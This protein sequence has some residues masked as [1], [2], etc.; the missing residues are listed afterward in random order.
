MSKAQTIIITFIVLLTIPF[1]GCVNS[2]KQTAKD[3]APVYSADWQSLAKHNESP[4]WFRDAK[5]GIYF[6]WGVYS[7]PA[8]GSEWYPRWMHFS[9]RPEYKYH[10]E[11]YGHSSEFGYHDFVPMFK[12]EKFDADEW[13]ELFEKTGAKFAG[14][15]AEHHDGFSMWASKVTPWNAGSMGPKRDITGEL[16]KAIRKRGMKFVT[17][18]HHARNLQRPNPTDKDYPDRLYYRDSH[19]PPIEGTPLV[20]DDPKLALLYGRMPAG[21]WEDQIWLG[22]LKEVIDNY[23]PDLIWF[24]SWLD[25]IPENKRQEFCAY[26]L[27]QAA[28]WDKDVVITFK[29]EDIPKDVGVLDLEKGRMNELTDY[30]WLTDD[31]ISKGSWCYTKDLEIKPTSQVLHVLIDIVSKNGQL[32]LNISPMADGTIPQNQKDVLLGIGKWLDGNGEAI[33][34]TRPWIT[35]GEGP[36]RLKS[37]GGFTHKKSGYLKYTAQDIRYTQ[38]K[39]GKTVYAILLGKPGTRNKVLLKSFAGSG[40]DIKNISLVSSGKT[41]K[42]QMRPEGLA[43]TMPRAKADMAFAFRIDL[44]K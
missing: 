28:K 3:T 4:E 36:T 16:A 2:Q 37:G 30:T 43:L 31:T 32:I 27:N 24:D 19:Y 17:T 5:F 42:W 33:Y 15:V 9:N 21:Q 20:S 29:Q 34:N 13:A 14:P 44:K 7:V 25:K 38:S 11:N 12:A 8:F 1:A 39:D 35:F 6:H 10:I 23:Q 22:K 40:L 26:Y 41:V 18:F